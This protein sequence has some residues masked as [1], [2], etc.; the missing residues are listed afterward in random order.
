MRSVINNSAFTTNL[1]PLLRK[2]EIEYNNSLKNNCILNVDESRYYNTNKK[3]DVKINLKINDQRDTI[4]DSLIF[5]NR[6]SAFSINNSN[7][8]KIE[9]EKNIKFVPNN[10]EMIEANFNEDKNWNIESI[11]KL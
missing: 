7:L 1:F 6:K 9:N 5:K 11:E 4:K 3:E 10:F 2:N 8:V